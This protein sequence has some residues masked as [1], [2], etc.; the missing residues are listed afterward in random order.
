MQIVIYAVS[1]D[2]VFACNV[3]CNVTHCIVG[4]RDQPSADIMEV[5]TADIALFY[6]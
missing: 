3:L 6:Q 1:C 4:L 5:F 2:C